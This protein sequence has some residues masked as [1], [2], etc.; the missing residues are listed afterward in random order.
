MLA[1]VRDRVGPGWPF[2]PGAMMSGGG[3]ARRQEAQRS[4]RVCP[5]W[6]SPCVFMNN[7]PRVREGALGGSS[8]FTWDIAG[9]IL[10]HWGHGCAV[11][12]AALCS[13]GLWDGCWRCTVCTGV[14]CVCCVAVRSGGDGSAV[15][16]CCFPGWHIWPC[17]RG[18]QAGELQRKCLEKRWPCQLLVLSHFQLGWDRV[19]TFFEHP[20]RPAW[21]SRY[22]IWKWK[23]QLLKC[24]RKGSGGLRH[25]GK[26]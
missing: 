1:N 10:L 12:G 13:C 15:V 5:P 26:L 18:R 16:L 17:V 8:S 25:L 19:H 7:A 3:R 2:P 6:T 22:S 21:V 14:Q 4:Q 9:L 11:P 23:Q 20:A 24:D